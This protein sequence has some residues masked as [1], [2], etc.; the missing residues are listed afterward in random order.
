MKSNAAFGIVYRIVEISSVGSTAYW[1]DLAVLVALTTLKWTGA[2]FGLLIAL[3][4]TF[5]AHLTY[6]LS[7]RWSKLKVAALHE[8]EVIK[9]RKQG[10]T[11]DAQEILPGVWLGSF[12]AAIKADELRRRNIT[13]VLSIGSEFSPV[14]PDQFCYL[15]AFAMDCPGQNILDYFEHT[16]RFID[17]A[18]SS[19]SSV[20]VHWCVTSFNPFLSLSLTSKMILVSLNDIIGLAMLTQF[21]HPTLKT[22]KPAFQEAPRSWPLT[23]SLNKALPPTKYS[24]PSEQFVPAFHPTLASKSNFKYGNTWSM[25]TPTCPPFVV[26][27]FPASGSVQAALPSTKMREAALNSS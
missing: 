23:Y 10:P 5:L 18:L 1:A 26:G 6:K 21:F 20:L 7:S 8:A 13:H 27:L 16:N 19:G 17:S 24:L 11:W 2:G 15:V 12:P 14:Y 9:K 4:V 22:A 3:V 25:G